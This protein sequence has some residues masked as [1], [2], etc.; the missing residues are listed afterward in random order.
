MTPR[1]D[2]AVAG[3]SCFGLDTTNPDYLS[4]TR[5]HICIEIIGGIQD[6]I[7]STLKVT[8]KVYKQ[9]SRS[10]LDIYRSSQVD[11]FDD[12][13][14]SYTITK[15]CERLKIESTQCKNILYGCIERLD[16]YRRNRETKTTPV[17]PINTSLSKH[18]NTLLQSK[19]LIGNLEPLIHD[20]GIPD[21]RLGLQLY[22]A[23][24]TRITTKPLHTIITGSHILAHS[25]ISNFLNSLPK[26]HSREVT[27]ISKHAL[28]YPPTP[29]YWDNKTLVL[30][31]LESIRHPDNTLL[32]Y[33][34]H[35][36]SKRHIAQ[37]NTQTGGYQSQQKDIT[38]TINLI[39][40]THKD[41]HPAFAGRHTLCL[42]IPNPNHLQDRLYEQEVKQLS[43]LWDTT[44]QV[45]AS[46]LLQQLQ[47]ELQALHIHNPYIEQIDL[48][49]FFGK[50]IIAL[51]KYLQLVNAITLLH[52]HQQSIKLRKTPN[53]KQ[54]IIDV[55]P[56]Y[57]HLALTLYK[58]LWLK[59]DD[60]LYFNVRG[61][62]TR[63]K[64]HLKKHHP[65]DYLTT[66]FK[67]KTIRK[68]L[69][70]SPVTL[71]RHLNTL[72]QYGKIE[73]TG[74]NNR[75][76]YD[77]KVLEWQDSP[78]KAKAYEALNAQIQQL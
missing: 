54:Q 60:E 56:P 64:I 48:T 35:H 14:V 36:Q 47:R 15:I 66:T 30:H 2:Q 6:V 8:L 67:H 31:Q 63:L 4:F 78:S 17:I 76:G 39:S 16:N 43:G 11:L 27:T 38:S 71:Q 23:S 61:T 3:E 40:Y 1:F 22:I 70:I 44:A 53:D 75:T 20:A 19:D 52:Q 69:K 51:G 50:D 74:G 24:I 12:H 73:R 57:M 9:G 45:E 46:Q 21:T 49:A 55:Q 72:E 33:L 59:K 34:L 68:T 65:N 7:L 29:D 58:E 41:Y 10:P 5:D 62:F 37:P 32:E 42:P 28:S 18:A 25:I 13:Q 26:E 77:Y